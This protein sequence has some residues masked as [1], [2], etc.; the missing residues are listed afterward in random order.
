MNPLS[1]GLVPIHIGQPEPGSEREQDLLLEQPSAVDRYSRPPLQLRIPAGLDW[2][3]HG[4]E[5]RWL[6]METSDCAVAVQPSIFHGRG[7]DEL[8]RFLTG[9]FRRDELAL[10][11][12]VIGDAGDE[13]AP[14]ALSS[15]ESSILIWEPV[16][17]ISGR[18]LPAGTRPEIAPGPSSAD[19][20]LALRLRARPAD[21][22]WWSLHLNRCRGSSSI[23]MTTG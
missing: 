7:A 8:K 3:K 18:R 6:G 19:R 16:T 9:A 12:A 13:S 21:A 17:V 20:D 10:V 5:S 14:G 23:G 1:P 2:Q 15:F 4:L 11:V 22:P